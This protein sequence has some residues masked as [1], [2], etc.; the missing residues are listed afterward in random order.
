MWN[1]DLLTRRN[2]GADKMALASPIQDGAMHDQ[3]DGNVKAIKSC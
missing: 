2:P 1:T 3:I